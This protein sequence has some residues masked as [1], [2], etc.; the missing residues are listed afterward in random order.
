MLHERNS[1]LLIIPT[2]LIFFRTK[3][4]LSFA[5]FLRALSRYKKKLRNIPT[6]RKKH[7]KSFSGEWQEEAKAKRNERKKM[8][9][10]KSQI[11]SLCFER[12]ASTR[13]TSLLAFIGLESW[14]AVGSLL[15]YVRPGIWKTMPKD[16]LHAFSG[17]LKSE[18]S[19]YGQQFGMFLII[20]LKKSGP[21]VILMFQRFVITWS[22]PT[23]GNTTFCKVFMKN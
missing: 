12:N 15:Q 7:H 9:I 17:R 22:S 19:N 2:R 20:F 21:R 14:L 18:A 10:E 5:V 1:F 13:H 11:P 6:S 23:P 16:F 8:F 3:N 4:K